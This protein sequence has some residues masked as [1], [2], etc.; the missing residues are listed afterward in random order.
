MIDLFQ[1]EKLDA[2]ISNAGG[3]GS[4][5]KHYG[6]LL[7][8][9]S[10]YAERAKVWDSKARDIHEW[11]VEIGY[12]TPTASPFPEPT[13]VTY[14]ESCHLCHGQKIT[15]QPREILRRLPGVTLVEL[16]ESN[17]CCG[18]A[19]I[20]NITQPT[21]A[22]KLQQRKVHSLQMTGA[23]AIAT[24]NPGCH[25]QI[26]NGLKAAGP[27]IDVTQPI[28]LLARAYRAEG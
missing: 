10:A 6:P 24:S 22:G 13:T 8:H 12:R 14:H 25:L 16:P 18:S 5:L 21:M 27:S 4:H 2:I 7:A 3:C 1:A 17:W 19:G 20:Y 26:Q 9:D 11:L 15:K 23:S 28:S